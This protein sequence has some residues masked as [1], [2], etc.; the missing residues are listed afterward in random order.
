MELLLVKQSHKRRKESS[1]CV[2]RT[3]LGSSE[4]PVNP[5][6]EHPPN[7]APALSIPSASFSLSDGPQTRS[8][9]LVLRV[10][11]SHFGQAS[12]A[13]GGGAVV[14]G[15]AQNGEENLEPASK[16]RKLLRG[17]VDDGKVRG[18]CILSLFRPWDLQYVQFMAFCS[19]L[20]PN[21]S[22]EI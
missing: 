4:V 11:P 7:K 15:S 18:C 22:P 20:N 13:G 9:T 21:L 1:G 16:R 3:A 2:E 14:N 17:S 5:S 19:E 6:E 12:G 10:H 8:Y